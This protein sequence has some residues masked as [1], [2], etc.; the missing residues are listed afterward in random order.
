L[1]Q[2]EVDVWRLGEQGEASGIDL[3]GVDDLRA[4]RVRPAGVRVKLATLGGWIE[5]NV[6][7]ADHLR[8]DVVVTIVVQRGLRANGAEPCVDPEVIAAT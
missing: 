6:L 7:R 8:K 2:D 3:V 4:D 1:P 5:P